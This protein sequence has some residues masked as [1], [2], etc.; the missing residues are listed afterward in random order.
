MSE[1][2]FDGPSLKVKRA[3]A[4]LENL[5]AVE[6]SFWLR[7]T[8]ELNVD[9]DS[10]T[11]NK[12]AVVRIREKPPELIH[13]LAAE[14]IY[15]L[16]S[17]L[18]QIAVA[19]ARMSKTVP[20]V[21]KIYFPTGDSLK[22]FLASSEKNTAGI[23]SD[24]VELIIGEKPYDGGNDDLRSIF[25]LANIDKHLELIPA[26]HRGRVSGL[27]HFTFK[28]AITGII[29]DDRLCPLDEGIVI[30]E[31]GPH[32]T[33]TPNSSNAQIQV[34]GDITFGNVSTFEGEP[35]FQKLYV[36]IDLVARLLQRF[37]K[38]CRNTGRI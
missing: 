34:S 15:H 23:D 9:V 37:V 21:K 30:S 24:L 28:N 3:N 14:I 31:L 27:S 26:A 29:I 20:N 12:I 11:G 10:E 2:F 32:G 4:L 5:Y 7:C 38:Y 8:P 25:Y 22:G 18:D 17:T 19:L 13:V 1:A 33:I 6:Q 35:I 16:R 36:L